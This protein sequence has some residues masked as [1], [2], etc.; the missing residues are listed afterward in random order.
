[1][2]KLTVKKSQTSYNLKW[3]KYH[4]TVH[5]FINLQIPYSHPP[6]GRLLSHMGRHVPCHHCCWV[7][8]SVSWEDP[9]AGRPAASRL[10]HARHASN[11]NGPRP[12]RSSSAWTA[13]WA[14][15]CMRRTKLTDPPRPEPEPEVVEIKADMETKLKVSPRSH[16]GAGE[17]KRRKEE[18]N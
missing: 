15:S 16:D 8:P 1:M 10:E 3:R 4:P 6:S 7:P 2:V 18:A 9:P 5:K 14:R 11:T 17:G 12:S 13:T